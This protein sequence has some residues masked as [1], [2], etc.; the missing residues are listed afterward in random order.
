MVMSEVGINTEV[1]SE[2]LQSKE[3]SV[4]KIDAL[5]SDQETPLPAVIEENVQIVPAKDG[6]ST[7]TSNDNSKEKNGIN[8][9]DHASPYNSNK[10]MLSLAP[11]E[12]TP[13]PLKIA[14][15][16]EEER[17]RSV[18]P[19]KPSEDGYNWRKYGQKRVKGN[20]FIRSYYRCSHPNCQVKKQVERSLDGQIKDIVYLGKHDHPG[21]QSTPQAVAGS[22]LS[23]HK[24]RPVEVPPIR[25]EVELSKSHE[26]TSQHGDSNGAPPV[27]TMTNS[28]ASLG[29]VQSVSNKP[30]TDVDHD[31]FLQSKRRKEDVNVANLSPADKPT[32]EQRFVVQTLSEVDIVNDGYRWRKYGQKLVKGNPNPRS[33]YRCSNAG[34]P[35]KKHVERA[36]HDAKVVL[37]TYE[38]QH[39]HGVPPSRTVTHNAAGSINS[40][41][42]NGVTTLKEHNDTVCSDVADASLALDHRPME[43][44]TSNIDPVQS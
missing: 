22:G 16:A 39:D 34:C 7:E 12:D 15:P 23:V 6:A 41:V 18:T 3:H 29:V 11:I 30:T 26:E 37:T 35:A 33:Y 1:D 13:T 20:E 21:P 32:N 36:S 9:R 24:E 5:Q 42:Q 28:D 14:Q 44:Q 4:S 38:G 31:E 27:T 40:P 43:Q 8:T 17:F 10:S 25:K 2:K 19:E